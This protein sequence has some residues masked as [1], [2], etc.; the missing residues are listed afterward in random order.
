MTSERPRRRRIG[1]VFTALLV[2]VCVVI[3][4][5]L[6]VWQVQRLHWKEDY[7]RRVAAAQ[8]APARPIAEALNALA[9]GRDV[10]YRRVEADCI[11]PRPQP[12]HLFVWDV[13]GDVH[14]WRAIAACRLDGDTLIAVDRGFFTEAGGRIEAPKTALP[15]MIHVMGQLRRPSGKSW[16]DQAGGPDVGFHSRL[17][18]IA[19]LKRLAPGR[20]APLIVM[21]ETETPPPPG[22]RPAPLPTNIPNNHLGYALTWF[23]LALAL[24]GVY[25]AALVKRRRS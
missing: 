1:E 11:K 3:L 25:A 20:Y 13:Q 23:G 15:P 12:R 19:E 5:W 4:V 18:A 21:A 2:L 24:I 9:T 17:A 7:L 8:A 14:G 22:V 6:G 16:F 10:E